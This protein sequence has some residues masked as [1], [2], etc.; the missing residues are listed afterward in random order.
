MIN[1]EE[2][3]RH[4]ERLHKR[5][6]TR[7]RIKLMSR[8]LQSRKGRKDRWGRWRGAY[9]NAQNPPGLEEGLSVFACWPLSLS[10]RSVVSGI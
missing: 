2:V 9:A 10:F 8:V 6:E 1:S 5:G 3:R 7:V 4:Q